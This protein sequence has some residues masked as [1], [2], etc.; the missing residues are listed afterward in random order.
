MITSYSKLSFTVKRKN[1]TFIQKI[2]D[3]LSKILFVKVNNAF[4]ETEI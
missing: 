3:L 2:S 1:K 4:I